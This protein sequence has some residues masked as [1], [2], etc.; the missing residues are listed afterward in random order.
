VMT[1]D[2]AHGSPAISKDVLGVNLPVWIDNTQPFIATAYKTAGVKL[3]RWPGGSLADTYHWAGPSA[4]NGEYFDPNS[5]FDN[6]MND[7]AV[8]DDLDVAITVNYG[9]NGACTT[10][11][12]DPSEAY[13]W[14]LHAHTM[15]WNV[16]YWTV[17]NEVFGSWE[18]DQH[19]SPHDPSTYVSAMNGS[20]GYYQQIKNGYPPAQVG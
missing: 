14:A 7:V 9:S 16:P 17:G 6:F 19:A 1:V 18:F 2:A 3:V 5:T 13:A 4:C 12:G 20:T 8:P 11:G 15:N 10:G